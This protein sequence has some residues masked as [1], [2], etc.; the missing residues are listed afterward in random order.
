MNCIKKPIRYKAINKNI[1]K[2]P[3]DE[4][5]KIEE[6]IQKYNLDLNIKY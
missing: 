3:N 5:V 1:D 2:L 6:L 4:I